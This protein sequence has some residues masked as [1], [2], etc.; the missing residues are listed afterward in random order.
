MRVR[1]N[2]FGRELP[3]WMSVK[4]R[5]GF[6]G[7]SYTWHD[8]SRSLGLEDAPTERGYERKSPW[9]SLGLLEASPRGV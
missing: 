3:P 9:R 6:V 1:P 8:L 5:R 2:A 4:G 7:T